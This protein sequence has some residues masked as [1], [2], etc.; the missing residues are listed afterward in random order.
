[1]QRP[2]RFFHKKRSPVPG[3]RDNSRETKLFVLG[4]KAI[5]KINGATVPLEDYKISSS[6]HGSTEL[7]V[8]FAVT[9]NMLIFESSA[10]REE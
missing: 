2:Y 9:G 8:K 3:P 6:M 5:L 7:E 4:E 1:M 10:S